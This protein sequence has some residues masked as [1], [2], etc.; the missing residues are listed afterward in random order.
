MVDYAADINTELY[1]YTR[2]VYITEPTGEQQDFVPLRLDL[3][4]N[5]FNFDLA[6]EDGLD[7]R[8][9]ELS[10]G[11]GVFQMWVA[12]WNV[13]DR[14]AT[15][16]FKIPRILASETRSLYAFWGYAYD[17]GVSDL[18]YLLGESVEADIVYTDN[19]ALGASTSGSSA[20]TVNSDNAFDGTNAYCDIEYAGWVQ[21]NYLV[22]TKINKLTARGDGSGWY[23]YGFELRASND[24]FNTQDV[25][26]VDITDS[27]SSETKTYLF[28]N[29]TEYYN[30]RVVN[31][32]GQTYWRVQEIEMMGIN[33]AETASTPVFLFGDDFNVS[34]LDVNKWPTSNGSMS[35][36][37]SQLDLG[38]DAWV[39]TG[40]VLPGLG[41]FIVED[42]IVGIGS[43]TST[44][45]AAHR[46]RFYG[47]ENVMGINYFWNGATQRQHDAVI[48]GSY[49]GYGGT[50]RGLIVGGYA[51]TYIGYYELTDHVYQGMHNRGG[52]FDYDDS[53]ERKVH[54]NTE[55]TNFRIYGEDLS[56]GNGV[57]IDWVIAREFEPEKD[58]TVDYRHL[59]I[60]HEYIGHQLLDNNEYQS[61]ATAVSFYHIS[62]MGGDPYRM[63]DDVTNSSTN[64]FVSDEGVT[65]GNLIIDFG[66]TST[67]AASNTYTHFDSEDTIIY[68]NAVKMSDQDTDVYGRDYWQTTTTS[69]WAAIEFPT[70]KDLSCLALKAVSG[71][72]DR[73]PSN[74]KFYGSQANPRFQGW[75]NKVLVYTGV[76]RDVEEEQVFYF[77]TGLTYYKY[78][79][80]EVLDTHGGNVAIQEWG[81]YERNYNTGKKTISQLRLH[82]V[83]FA[84]NEYF[85]P[86]QVEL[87]GTNDGF[88]W[89][90]LLATIDT[91]TPFTDYAYGRWSRYTF[92][93]TDTY[94]IYRLR[95][96][97]NWRAATD[98]IMI[99]E[100]EMVERVE[101]ADNYRILAGSNNNINNIWADPTSSKD[102]GT[103]YVTTD[104]FNTIENEKLIDYITIS[105]SVDD[106]NVK[107]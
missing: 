66:R 36:S 98:Q 21:C 20:G 35:I 30:Y 100:W 73:M 80:L 83:A 106:F 63:S 13:T 96:L 102:S 39:R 93:N 14:I 57:A 94:Y 33:E 42:G 15:V 107:L 28:G 89:N 64:I 103:L 5:N 90:L 91:P 56:N 75:N 58:L 38:I 7:F 85:F 10:N 19:L 9:A 61:D 99:A 22:P 8:L 72:S 25:L 87:Y 84:N 17:T 82:P 104:V 101:E 68:Y 97:D 95:C 45:I 37:N 16:W 4:S 26:V 12:Y 78:Y 46:Y 40:N 54:R 41:K 92:D 60:E 79:I 67:N 18:R 74:F 53:W 76:A 31:D 51:Q 88:T 81:L 43:P 71:S 49:V 32:K 52:E 77:N 34:S 55:V 105:G 44:S 27:M 29:T 23:G 65:E 47:G 86:K 48:A 62:D 69:G 50:N 1:K 70:T 24:D 59:Y 6:R 3:N 2:P 11:S